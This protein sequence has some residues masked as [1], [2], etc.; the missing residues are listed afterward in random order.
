MMKKMRFA[1]I[2]NAKNRVVAPLA[3]I[4]WNVELWF[5]GHRF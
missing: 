2:K 3:K 1:V 4:M 5:L